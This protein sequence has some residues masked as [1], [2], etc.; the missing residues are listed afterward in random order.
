[1]EDANRRLGISKKAND[2][3]KIKPNRRL[4]GMTKS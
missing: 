1:M 2:F 4:R 3:D